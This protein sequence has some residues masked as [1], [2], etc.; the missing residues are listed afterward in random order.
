M[1]TEAKSQHRAEGATSSVKLAC[2]V[3][4]F[5][6]QVGKQLPLHPDPHYMP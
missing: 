1:T 5:S 3:A 4:I 2:P 6:L